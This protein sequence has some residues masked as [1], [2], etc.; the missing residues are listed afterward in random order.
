M[1]DSTL[2]RRHFLEGSGLVAGAAV[3]AGCGS[4]RASEAGSA[5]GSAAAAPA[6]GADTIT[7]GQGAEPR[8]LDPAIYDDGESAKVAV[9]VYENLV[10]YEDDSTEIVPS[11]ADSWEISDDGLTYT[12]HLHE[13]IKFTDGEPFTADAVKKN[14]DRMLEPNRTD[15]MPY[16]SFVFGTPS[17]GTGVDQIT[18]V[19]DTTLEIH[20]V[21]PNTP[22]LRTLAMCTAPVIAS[23]K[24]IE[25]GTLGEQPVGTGPFV[26][27]SWT[28]GSN[29]VLERNEDYWDKDNMPSVKNVVFQFI[30]EN[31][32]RVQALTTG[33]CDL[34]DGIDDS[35]VDEIKNT[36][37]YDVWAGEGMTINYLAFNTQSDTFKDEAAR[38]A[39]AKAIN[40]E[41]LVDKLYGEYGE[42]ANSIMPAAVADYTSDI[43]QTAYDP[44]AAKKELADLGITSVKCITYSN[45]RPY[46]PKNGQVLAETIQGYLTE[47]GVQMDITPYDWTAYKE[48]VGKGDFDICFYGWQGDNGDPDNFMNLLADADPSMN[49]A[50]FDDADYKKLIDQAVATPDGDEREGLYHQL[51]ELAAE[52]QP[53][54]PLNHTKNLV[55]QNKNCTGWVFH[56]TGV[57][58]LEHATKEA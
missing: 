13:G 16:A 45:P 52:K 33:T 5:A 57:I 24:A 7:Y 56:T 1:L 32:S 4:K 25:A 28:K 54:V 11:L 23:P 40:V 18:A 17:E 39:I 29:I 8:S 51:E 9:Q 6:A 22:F 27:K 44:D 2:S 30:A 48:E 20:L 34:I 12:F 3:L 15:D 26:F 37:G 49:V 53:W 36:D 19:D 14:Y 10:K 31:A 42:V 46:N 21:A 55:G 50:R 41:E 38:K 47:V 35:V 58:R 43:K